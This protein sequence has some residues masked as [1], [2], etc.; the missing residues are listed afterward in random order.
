MLRIIDI[1]W[2]MF[3][4]GCVVGAGGVWAKML[5]EPEV[6]RAVARTR[7]CNGIRMRG[8]MITPSSR[9]H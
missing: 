7:A 2:F 8:F 5:V 1:I 6:E 4:A 9:G 3:P